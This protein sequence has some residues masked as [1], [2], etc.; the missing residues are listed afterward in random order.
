MDKLKQIVDRLL[1]RGTGAA[2]N[3]IDEARSAASENYKKVHRA[4]DDSSA[5]LDR[6]L[7]SME[8]ATI[9]AVRK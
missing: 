1:G 8:L 5:R 9:R 3:A 6:A 2:M 4:L 7:S